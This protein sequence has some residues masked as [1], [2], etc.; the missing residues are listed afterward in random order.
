MI[1]WRDISIRPTRQ[2]IR[3]TNVLSFVHHCL[4]AVH[5]CP[6]VIVW[7]SQCQLADNRTRI[8]TPQLIPYWILYVGPEI[9]SVVNWWRACKVSHWPAS[10]TIIA[11]WYYCV[12]IYYICRYIYT[13]IWS[14][15]ITTDNHNGHSIFIFKTF[16][17]T[18][19]TFPLSLSTQ[20]F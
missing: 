17:F 13:C 1:W 5:H 18:F 12:Y 11:R 6:Y 14:E 7:S 4:P 3:A 20:T 2:F 15:S 19:G 9:N 8:R 10:I 16:I